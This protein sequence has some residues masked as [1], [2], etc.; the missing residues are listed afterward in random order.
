[1][2]EQ[3]KSGLP[4]VHRGWVEQMC[5]FTS[6]TNHKAMK[7]TVSGSNMKSTASLWDHIVLAELQ[8]DSS[9]GV[10]DCSIT[11]YLHINANYNF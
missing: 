10:V 6:V 3:N 11:A 7:V 8:C 5:C 2:H 9:I 1:M 4:K